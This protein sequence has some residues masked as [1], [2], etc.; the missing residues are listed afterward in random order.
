M[1]VRPNVSALAVPAAPIKRMEIRDLATSIAL[2]ALFFMV[3]VGLHPFTE[4]TSTPGGGEGGGG[5]MLHQLWYTGVLI[6]VIAMSQPLAYPRR[7][8]SL[9]LPLMLVLVWCAFS[10]SWSL[11]PG[12]GV[13]RLILTVMIIMSIFGAVNQLGGSRAAMAVRIALAGI[14]LFN[15]FAMVVSP[16]AI[17]QNT[18]IITTDLAGAWRGAFHHKNFAG[19]AAAAMVIL[20]VFDARRVPLWLRIG[21]IAASSYFLYRTESK[22]SMGLLVL[23]LMTG[24]AY[25]RYNPKFRMMLIP[26]TLIV[27]AGLAYFTIAD[28]GRF[29][30][31]LYDQ[32]AFTG[33]TQIW[34]RM[35]AFLADNPLQ[36]A[37]FGS[38][39]NIGV[40]NPIS[41]YGTGWF[42]EVGNGHQGYLDL[43]VQIG[44]PGAVLAIFALVLLP[45]TRLLTATRVDRS[46]GALAIALVIFC[47]GHNFTETSMLDRD[48]IV[49]TLLMLGLALTYDATRRI[50]AVPVRIHNGGFAA[51]TT[52]RSLS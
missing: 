49:E 13:R 5:D 20:F 4:L 21:M 30:A 43:A 37:G 16:I 15:Y 33:R 6:T 18:E 46:T 50:A 14:L 38:F 9:P 25:L 26:L 1:A 11:A 3:M 31:T 10:L 51:S 45:I 44:V 35:L 42:T 22:T 47:A 8:F 52:S 19:P 23:S 39:W 41:H 40:D 12:I 24:A 48:S 27:T 36:G 34:R 7:I 17:H 2:M 29:D 28:W 32:N